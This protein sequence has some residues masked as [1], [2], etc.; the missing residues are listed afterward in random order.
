MSADVL[1]FSERK[2]RKIRSSGLSQVVST[3]V[4]KKDDIL[5]QQL[6]DKAYQ[7][8]VIKAKSKP[9]FLRLII[10]LVFSELRNRPDLTPLLFPN[11][12]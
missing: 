12:P 5:L 11:Q 8:G 3:K 4:S 10:G 7:V 9:E 6:T 2:V 1:P